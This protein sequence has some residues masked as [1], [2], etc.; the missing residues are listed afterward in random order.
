MKDE[1]PDSP[2]SEVERAWKMIGDLSASEQHF[3]DIK[4]QCRTLAST[5][6]L[7]AFG[8]MGFLLTNELAVALPTE[9][10]VLAVGFA[11][12][13]GLTLLWVLDL[14]VYHRLLDASFVEALKIEE[15]YPQLPQVRLNMKRSQPSGQTTNFQVWFY[16]V[17]INAP[18]LFG[19][20]L[21][22]YWCLQFGI[23]LG[24]AAL[25]SLSILI[26]SVG[27]F[28]ARGSSNPAVTP[29]TP[30]SPGKS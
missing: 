9:V 6:L 13:T 1:P 18:L 11:A 28:V 30:G 19:G 17:A 24:V 7:A 27:S 8:A 29:L 16:I 26:F 25:A 5:W 22:S 14:L 3:N 20:L 10:V 2:E 4:A 15:K 23:A 21:F 12:S